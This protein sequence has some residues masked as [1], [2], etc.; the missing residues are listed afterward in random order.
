MTSMI[1]G[2]LNISRLD[3]GKMLLERSA[4]DLKSL[5]SEL[6]DEIHST[7][8][9][10]RVVFEQAESINLYADR[11][12]ISQVIHNLI[13]NAVKYSPI[14]SDINISY[15][16]S[17]KG[18]IEIRVKDNG[19]GIGEQDQEQIFERYYRIKS[20]TMGSIAGFGIGLYL[21]REIIEL[22]KG[23]I[24]IESSEGAGATFIIEIPS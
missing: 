18:T 23:E 16:I 15:S 24:K 10:H 17:A 4:F 21:C 3:S 12:K 19:M 2:F 6:E 9:T 7:V 11:E 20:P 13:S 14:G 5:F 8:H 1:D 22:H